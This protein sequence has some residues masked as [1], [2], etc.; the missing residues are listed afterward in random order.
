ML[1]LAT[2]ACVTSSTG[3]QQLREGASTSEW[4][5]PS[6]ML[7]EQIGEQLER[8]PWTH[9]AE[10][11]EQIRWLAGVGEAGYAQILPVCLDE[12]ADVAGAALAALGATGDS[13]LV[14]P[15]C[16]LQWPPD[17]QLNKGLRLERARALVRLGDWTELVP[18]IDG[19]EDEDVWTRSWCAQCLFETTKHRFDFKAKAATE[20]RAASVE[21]WRAWLDSRK[22]EGILPQTRS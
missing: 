3:G 12:R 20:E 4:L 22:V 17:D 18:L 2:S 16:A 9:G 6:A 19:L 8:L 14:A 7:K 11:V 5:A 15:I 1:F 13:R 10:R 21:R